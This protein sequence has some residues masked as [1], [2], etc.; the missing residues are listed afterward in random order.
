M[1]TSKNNIFQFA[2]AVIAIVGGLTALPVEQ[3][4]A[5]DPYPAYSAKFVCGPL[6]EDADVVR[7]MYASTINLHNPQLSEVTFMKQ[8]VIALPERVL[9]AKGIMSLPVSEA[10]KPGEAMGVDCEDI[11]LLF[12]TALSK[13]TKHIEGF[14]MIS[15]PSAKT[16]ILD[17]VGKYSARQLRC[18]KHRHHHD[19]DD[20]D[21]GKHKGK[22]K[23]WCHH[24]KKQKNHEDGGQGK[25]GGTDV[26]TLDV[27]EVHPKMVLPVAAPTPP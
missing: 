9:P 14:L 12:G 6:G 16:D 15:V 25:H 27:E 21:D 7:G 22:H 5:A 23:G 13:E 18:D 4:A 2:I 17:V 20:D 8:A 24:H 1:K 26:E 19:D 3:A 10:L 11:R